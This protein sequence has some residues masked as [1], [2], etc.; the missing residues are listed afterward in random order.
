[1]IK[2]VTTPEQVLA[3]ELPPKTYLMMR[4]NAVHQG[5]ELLPAE[6]GW[7]INTKAQKLKS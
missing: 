6:E 2:K 3:A 4:L 1:M 7:A 5:R